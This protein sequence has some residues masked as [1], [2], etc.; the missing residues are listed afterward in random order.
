MSATDL[1]A[2]LPDSRTDIGALRVVPVRH[3]ARAIGTLD[4]ETMTSVTR[5]LALFL[6]FA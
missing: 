3:R 5:S 4:A 6:G 1:H 2:A